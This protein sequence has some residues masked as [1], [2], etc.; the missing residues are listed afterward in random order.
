MARSKVRLT[1][2]SFWLEKKIVLGCPLPKQEWPK[3]R[4]LIF[5]ASS[6]CHWKT[7]MSHL[8]IL[9]VFFIPCTY[10]EQWQ[11]QKLSI[12]LTWSAPPRVLCCGPLSSLS[13]NVS[14]GAH[15]HP[16]ADGWLSLYK[17][18]SPIPN[19]HSRHSC[20]E[21]KT[22]LSAVI[23]IQLSFFKL[24]QWSWLYGRCFIFPV[25][26]S[27]SF[28]FQ[29]PTSFEMML[30]D[31]ISQLIFLLM[32]S[33]CLALI[34]PFN[35]VPLLHLYLMRTEPC[36]HPNNICNLGLWENKF[37]K[38]LVYGILYALLRWVVCISSQ[39][40]WFIFFAHWAIGDAS[41]HKA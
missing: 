12:C 4:C 32:S 27:I 2:L 37:C 28:S 31:F 11:L 8:P 7:D 18:S 23:P 36:W 15:S 39:G 14:L 29:K 24:S 16:S 25:N 5:W 13:V 3:K 9:T 19:S 10:Q 40:E 35:D 6:F 17:H 22:C 34:L 1:Y 30:L 38:L 41:F 33:T 26:I 21:A 20:L